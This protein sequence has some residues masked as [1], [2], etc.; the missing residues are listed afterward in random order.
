[1]LPGIII[2]KRKFKSYFHKTNIM[3]SP[4]PVQILEQLKKKRSK[5]TNEIIMERTRG[6]LS[7]SAIGGGVGIIYA[8]SAKKSL[9]VWGVLGILAGGIISHFYINKKIIQNN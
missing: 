7:G 4:G 8:F 9:L 1:V 6:T 5:D 2:K 3:P